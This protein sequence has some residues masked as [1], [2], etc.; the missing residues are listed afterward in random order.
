M[1]PVGSLGA[2]SKGEYNAVIRENVHET[3]IIYMM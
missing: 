3:V 2:E 1:Q